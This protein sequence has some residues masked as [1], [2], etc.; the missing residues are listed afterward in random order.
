[1]LI[2]LSEIPAAKQ[3]VARTSHALENRDPARGWE[4]LG[5]VASDHTLLEDQHCQ[6]ETEHDPAKDVAGFP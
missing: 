2:G 4:A 6:R 3:A 1:M 5:Q